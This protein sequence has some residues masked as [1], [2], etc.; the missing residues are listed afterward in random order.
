MKVTHLQKRTGSF[1]SSSLLPLMPLL[2]EGWRSALR[3]QQGYGLIAA[4]LCVLLRIFPTNL[5]K[6]PSQ[7]L[8]YSQLVL[9]CEPG[10]GIQTLIVILCWTPARSSGWAVAADDR[11]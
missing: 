9:N 6:C 11:G 8:L 4:R 1:F 7:I 3:W 10:W 2:V 5:P